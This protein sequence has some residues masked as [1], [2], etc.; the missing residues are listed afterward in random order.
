MNKIQNI[1]LLL[2]LSA[3][4]MAKEPT[5]AI[6]TT[7]ISNDTQKYKIANNQFVCKQY[8]V[9]GIDELYN[10]SSFN[11]KCKSSIKKFYE[12]RAD[13]KY[14]SYKKL[15]VGQSYVL[16]FKNNRCIVSVQG[17]KS[18]S[19]FLLEEGLAVRKPFIKDKEYESYLFAAQLRAKLSKKGIW[20]DSITRECIANIYKK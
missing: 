7:I 5:I 15:H 16:K 3:T 12:K 14:Y 20:K 17:E 2:L 13:L 1:L 18:L 11:T 19:E 10:L 6:L 9:I 4:L 8:A